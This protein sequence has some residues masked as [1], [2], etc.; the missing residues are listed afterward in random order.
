MLKFE[1][2]LQFQIEKFIIFCKGNKNDSVSLNNF[3]VY[4]IFDKSIIVS[5]SK[6]SIYFAGG[7]NYLAFFINE[8]F[9][10]FFIWNLLKHSVE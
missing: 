4:C 10:S 5:D 3:T 8:F 2:V 7:S 6:I 1:Q 9:I